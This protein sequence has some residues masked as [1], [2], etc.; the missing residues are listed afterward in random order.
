MIVKVLSTYGSNSLHGIHS[1]QEK[2][3]QAAREFAKQ[4]HGGVKG[5]ENC[6]A[7][8]LIGCNDGLVLQIT[9]WEVD[10]ALVDGKWVVL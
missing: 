4:L 9:D 8:T 6:E 3:V 7:E 1:T 2:A 10:R 5:I